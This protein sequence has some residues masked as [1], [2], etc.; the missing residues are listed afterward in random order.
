MR[1]RNASHWHCW[2]RGCTRAVTPR[3]D[4]IQAPRRSA[5]L[6]ACILTTTSSPPASGATSSS[7]SFLLTIYCSPLCLC[8]SPDVLPRPSRLL[9]PSAVRIAVEVSEVRCVLTA[10]R[11]H[12]VSDGVL[13]SAVMTLMRRRTSGNCAF[14]P[15]RRHHSS[16][17]PRPGSDSV[18]LSVT[19]ALQ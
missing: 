16:R 9:I 7:M 11:R 4:V 12:A 10:V 1:L 14:S 13:E 5:H 6:V 3:T 8:T 18:R 19:P 2:S 17:P 15:F